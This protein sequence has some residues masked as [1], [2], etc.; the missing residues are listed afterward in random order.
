M[1]CA[2]NLC[3]MQEKEK[4]SMRPVRDFLAQKRRQEEQL[5]AIAQQLKDSES[6]ADEA[7]ELAK[8]RSTKK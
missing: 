3:A 7:A 5:A 1:I 4:Y 6:K 8:A 2:A